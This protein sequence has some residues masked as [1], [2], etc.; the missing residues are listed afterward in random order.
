MSLPNRAMRNDN[1]YHHLMEFDLQLIP[2]TRDSKTLNDRL[3]IADTPEIIL[4]ALKL[5][6]PTSRLMSR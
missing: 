3:S 4:L 1:R 5:P 2:A 6:A